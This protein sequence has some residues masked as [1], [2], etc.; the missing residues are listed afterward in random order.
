M[1]KKIEEVKVDEIL[2]EKKIEEPKKKE[3]KKRKKAVKKDKNSEINTSFVMPAILLLIV[4]VSI[5]IIPNV[6]K[7]KDWVKDK[8]RKDVT[9]TTTTTVKKTTTTKPIV[10]GDKTGAVTPVLTKDMIPIRYNQV[11]N[12]WVIADT[13]N[14]SDDYW[15]NYETGEWA[16]GVFV[17]ENGTKTREYYQNA[18]PGTEI[19]QEDIISYFVWIPRYSYM[20]D[21]T[22]KMVN[23]KFETT[24]T[25]KSTGNAKT[26]YLTHPAFTYNNKELSGIWVGKYEVTGTINE[27]TI[28]DGDSLT[29]KNI[30]TMI[31]TLDKAKTAYNLFNTSLNIVRNT[32][33]GAITYLTYSKY[34][35]CNTGT[36][37]I[38][39][40]MD[41]ST[42]NITGIF[43]LNNGSEYVMANFGQNPSYSGVLQNWFTENSKYIDLYTDN[44][45][46]GDA[47]SDLASIYTQNNITLNTYNSWFVRGDGIIFAYAAGN[48]SA[49]YYIGYR[50]VLH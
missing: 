43:E 38:D 42:N 50:V 2:E 30:G 15:F 6:D 37:T 19:K 17:K 5:V 20:V 44:K 13:T 10:K 39:M 18:K 25:D 48:G 40:Q 14:P 29:Y 8:T 9:I 4:A 21:E 27:P 46:V 3:T 36:C 49:N 11:S 23:I 34:G 32:E 16:N 35:V 24:T 26:T 47:T 7:I 1:K 33:W 28:L 31:D 22:N 41:S 12:I 45:I